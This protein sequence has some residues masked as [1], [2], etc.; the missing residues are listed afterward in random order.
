MNL[1]DKQKQKQILIIPR[2][3]IHDAGESNVRRLELIKCRIEQEKTH[4]ENVRKLIGVCGIAI[5]KSAY[6]AP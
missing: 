3:V 2:I 4:R 6:Y 5:S 1:N